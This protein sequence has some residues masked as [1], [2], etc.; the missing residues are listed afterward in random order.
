MRQCLVCGQP[1]EKSFRTQLTCSPECL[2]MMVKIPF[3]FSIQE[4]RKSLQLQKCPEC[5]LEFWW[6]ANRMRRRI[7][8]S[9]ACADA[10]KRRR[11]QER[12]IN[13]TSKTSE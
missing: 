8:C 11:T 7:Y 3:A 10:A 6:T 5:G 13:G 4:Y 9:Q 2:E 12:R 1:F